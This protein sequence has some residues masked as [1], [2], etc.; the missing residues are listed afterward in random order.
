[1]NFYFNTVKYKS[2]SAKVILKK[3]LKYFIKI[4]FKYDITLERR[5]L[6]SSN[7][8]EDKN[9]LREYVFNNT[10]L[11]ND[12]LLN[13]KISLEYII[14]NKIDGDI[15]ECGVWKGGAMAFGAKI[16][17]IN[18]YKKNI[19]LYDIFDHCPQADFRHDG[20]RAIKETGIKESQGLLKP[21][22]N[23][24]DNIV[25]NGPGDYENVNEL[26]INKIGYPSDKVILVKGYFQETLIEK[27]NLPEKISL[28]RLD[29]DWYAS[30][31]VCLENLYPLV[32]KGG[33]VIIDDYFAYDGC[34]KAVDE[35]ILE[36]QINPLLNRLDKTLVYWIKS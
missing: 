3:Y 22:S 12:K 10:M 13:L 2:P 17:L 23:T 29:G 24:Y 7:L 27:E 16:L 32:E 14:N 11:S 26:L 4:I 1:M 9:F 20:E 19:Y 18:N 34:K 8:L 5:L 15:V 35:F 31:K 33:V 6:N 21:I 28:L 25:H 36:R 30:T